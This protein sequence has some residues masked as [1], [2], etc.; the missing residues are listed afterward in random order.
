MQI[1]LNYEGL[2][3]AGASHSQISP[4]LFTFHRPAVQRTYSCT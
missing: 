2:A 4:V 1:K 3:C